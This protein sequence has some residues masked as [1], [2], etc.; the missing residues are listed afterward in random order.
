MDERL[1]PAKKHWETPVVTEFD[2]AERTQFGDGATFDGTDFSFD[3]GGTP[4]SPEN[5]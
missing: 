4:S 2:I 1:N 3:G 5:S